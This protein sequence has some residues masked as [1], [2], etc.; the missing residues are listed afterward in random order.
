MTDHD[1]RQ[2]LNASISRP[3]LREWAV[4]VIVGP[5]AHAAEIDG[6]MRDQR[7]PIPSC[8]GIYQATATIIPDPET[9]SAQL[10]LTCSTRPQDEAIVSN[11]VKA[12]VLAGANATT[13][14]PAGWTA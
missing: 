6:F 14:P 13:E 10:I 3:G 5:V 11:F 8:I 1:E 2:I 4:T 7:T 9:A 12:V